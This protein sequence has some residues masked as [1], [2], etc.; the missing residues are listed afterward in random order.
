MKQ[1]I[2][3]L[4]IGLSALQVAAQNTWM[5]NKSAI[6]Q[7]LKEEGFSPTESSEVLIKFKKEGTTYFVL[8]DKS[9]D[10][11]VILSTN[12][13]TFEPEQRNAAILAAN[14]VNE[15]TKV[16][17]VYCDD[18]TA[19]GNIEMFIYKPEHFFLAFYKSMSILASLNEKL[20]E[21]Y[22]AATNKSPIHVTN[23]EVANTDK[24]LKIDIDYGK[25]IYSYKTMYLSPRISYTSGIKGKVTLYVKFY[26]PDG[27]QKSANSP[28]GY[29]Y[30]TEATLNE[31]GNLIL[32]AWGN[33]TKG[34][35]KSG[36]YKFEIWYDNKCLISK[37]FTIY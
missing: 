15:N 29:T 19:F 10:A 30:S 26:S 2:L 5:T 9:D 8:F 23:L 28:E 14:I 1:Y 21:A 7:F 12:I 34:F 3:I 36:A 27:L 13:N 20:K 4:L 33:E 32:S 6:V 17:K 31:S 22:D 37:D 25:M 16:V 24:N 35:W 11:F 18:D